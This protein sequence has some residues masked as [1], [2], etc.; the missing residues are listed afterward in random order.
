[1]AFTND[2]TNSALDRVRLTVGD[3]DI[4]DPLLSDEVY[5]YFIDTTSSEGAA[6][7]KAIDAI[8]AMA[9]RLVDET[10]DEVSAKWSQLYDQYKALKKDLV[11]NPSL[12]GGAS[13]SII[14]TGSRSEETDVCFSTKSFRGSRC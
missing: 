11:T 4:Y 3:T 13:G 8:I 7:L 14:I 6:A 9:A 1:M 2:P 5:Q 10:T 12:S